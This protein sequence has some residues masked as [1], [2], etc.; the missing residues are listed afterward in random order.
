MVC[1]GSMI[2]FEAMA[3]GI[4]PI[5]FDNPS[6]YGSVSLAEYEPALFIVRNAAELHG[7]IED[8][9]TDAARARAKR[10]EWPAMLADVMGDLDAP[11][12]PQL[13]AALD[14]FDRTA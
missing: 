9:R 2:A 14:A 4:M 10:A 1:I 11:I 13:D 5:V 7:A 12:A 8:V 6:T 3:L